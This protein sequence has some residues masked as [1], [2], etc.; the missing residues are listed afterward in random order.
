MFNLNYIIVN[1]MI[2]SFDKNIF[3][4]ILGRCRYRYIDIFRFSNDSLD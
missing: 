2:K 4:L 3:K 1:E